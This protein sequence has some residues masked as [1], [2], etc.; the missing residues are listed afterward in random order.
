MLPR[1]Q[2]PGSASGVSPGGGGGGPPPFNLTPP[3]L[4]PRFSWRSSGGLSGSLKGGGP[5]ISRFFFFLS[6]R[7]IRS[8]LGSCCG[9]QWSCLC[10]FSKMLTTISPS[11]FFSQ[12][13]C[14]RCANTV[15]CVVHHDIL[16]M[17]HDGEMKIFLRVCNV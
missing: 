17:F 1:M 2:A 15:G 12:L 4:H 13:H 5:K 7:K 9:I 8:F 6:R 3:P 16:G 14:T 11:C 10:F